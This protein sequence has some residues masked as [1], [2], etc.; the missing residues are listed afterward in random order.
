[1]LKLSQREP[2]KTRR[3]VV[4]FTDK[5][6]I[7]IQSHP[8]GQLALNLLNHGVTFQF[9]GRHVAKSGLIRWWRVIVSI[10]S[11]PPLTLIFV[12]PAERSLYTISYSHVAN[13]YSIDSTNAGA[14]SVPYHCTFIHR[15]TCSASPLEIISMRST[16]LIIWWQSVR[17][18]SE[19]VGLLAECVSNRSLSLTSFL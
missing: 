9:I 17:S 19:C 2:L 6:R 15:Y 8:F 14:E 11:V 4:I 1:M 13:S 3:S 7:Y 18:V 16:G 10:L 12:F 5:S